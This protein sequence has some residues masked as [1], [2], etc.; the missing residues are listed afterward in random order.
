MLR[1]YARVVSPAAALRCL[2]I[3][4]TDATMVFSRAAIFA[5]PLKGSSAKSWLLAMRAAWRHMRRDICC[6]VIAARGVISA[7]FR[8]V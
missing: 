6:A 4:I 1:R 7:S 2:M 3:S 5:M 8:R